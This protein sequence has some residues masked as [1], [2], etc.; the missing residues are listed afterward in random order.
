MMKKTWI[1]LVLF[2]LTHASW[3]ATH[4]HPATTCFDFEYSKSEKRWRLALGDSAQF[5]FLPDGAKGHKE[6]LEF[7]KKVCA[8]RAPFALT[9]TEGT[10]DI[11][12]VESQKK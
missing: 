7:L 5:A 3:G 12:A 4:T 1:F 8:S 11:V 2:L 10:R 6:I 9:V